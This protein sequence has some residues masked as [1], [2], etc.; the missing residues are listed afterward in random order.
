MTG[1]FDKKEDNCFTMELREL[2]KEINNLTRI[3]KILSKFKN[4]WLKQIK[5][6]TNR[7][8]PFLQELDES[9]K[10]EINNCLFSC[11][12]MFSQ[13]KYAQF[14]QE[15]LSSLAQYL[16]ELKLTSLN[17]DKN[18]SRV[19][20]NKFINDDFLKLKVLI[21]EVNQL[22]FNLKGLKQIYNKVNQLLI[23]NI[24]LEH[25]V[26]LMD[27]PHKNHLDSLLLISKKQK[28]LLKILGKEFIS[29][30]KEMKRKKNL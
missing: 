19:L 18:K 29:L 22:E 28:K 23:Q 15:K 24:P 25:S 16:I 5:S 3:D 11:Q 1:G 21:D 6:D 7:Q 4:S 10:K 14:T 9:I 2:K 27:S 26:A 30:A 17:K 20:L 12:K 13:L 8:F